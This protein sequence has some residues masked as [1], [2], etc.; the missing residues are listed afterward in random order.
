MSRIK[1]IPGEK[2]I[3]QSKYGPTK[4]KKIKEIKTEDRWES[5]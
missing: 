3:K 5:R 4:R 1:E 2:E